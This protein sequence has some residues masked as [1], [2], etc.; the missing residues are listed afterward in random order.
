MSGAG[1]NEANA[2]DG[3][4]DKNKQHSSDQ[5]WGHEVTDPVVELE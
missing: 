4:F 1:E 5:H 3:V 2:P